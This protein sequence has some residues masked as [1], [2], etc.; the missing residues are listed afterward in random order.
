MTIADPIHEIWIIL[1]PLIGIAGEQKWETLYA[2]PNDREHT[3]EPNHVLDTIPKLGKEW[4][5]S[6]DFMAKSFKQGWTETI[7]LQSK[8]AGYTA[9]KLQASWDSLTFT[10]LR[11]YFFDGRQRYG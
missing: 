9:V 2:L 8:N 5:I 3:L 6:F 11:I 1:T 7:R 10:A 4:K